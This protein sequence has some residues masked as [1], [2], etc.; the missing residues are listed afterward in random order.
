[1]SRKGIQ[2]LVNNNNALAYTDYIQTFPYMSY[3]GN[4]LRA[5][6]NQ[7]VNSGPAWM[8]VGLRTDK[9]VGLMQKI[10][11]IGPNLKNDYNIAKRASFMNA[12]VDIYGKTMYD[13][14]EPHARALFGGLISS[15]S[16]KLIQKDMPRAG[17]MLKHGAKWLT[18]DLRKLLPTMF[19]EGVE[20]GVQHLLQ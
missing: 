14:V 6:G 18:P 2:K 11:S 5:I 10:K 12:P 1:M 4:V 16:R 8:R 19:I 9:N 3:S 20:E 15:A 7:F 13:K 17:L